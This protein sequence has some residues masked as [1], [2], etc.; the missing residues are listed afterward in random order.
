MEESKTD[1][2][3]TNQHASRLKQ[4]SIYIQQEKKLSGI[5]EEIATQSSKPTT[6]ELVFFF[7]KMQ[8]ITSSLP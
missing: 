7:T 3:L 5:R 8:A 6:N 2:F 4:L 1:T